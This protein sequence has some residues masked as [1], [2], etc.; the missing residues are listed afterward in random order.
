MYISDYGYSASPDCWNQ[1]LTSYNSVA[2]GKNWLIFGSYQWTIGHSLGTAGSVYS[3]SG[4]GR[5]D[6]A[7]ATNS[8]DIRPVFYLSDT[9]LFSDGIGTIENPFIL[10]VWTDNIALPNL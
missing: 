10:S 8:Y 1:S 6:N 9:T 3:I 7:P 4:G 2:K 5:L